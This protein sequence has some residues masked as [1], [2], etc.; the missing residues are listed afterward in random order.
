MAFNTECLQ[1]DEFINFYWKEK[2]T[3]H[4]GITNISTKPLINEREK[5]K[6]KLKEELIFPEIQPL[7]QN[8]EKAFN[9]ECLAE[10]RNFY[11]PENTNKFTKIQMKRMNVLLFA[12]MRKILEDFND[13]STIDCISKYFDSIKG[14]KDKIN[15]DSLGI[16]LF[17]KLVSDISKGNVQIKEKNLD[18]ML[19]NNK[20]IRPLSFYGETKEYF[21]LDKALDKIIDFLKEIISDEK[22]KDINK[23]KA[24]KIIFN[25]ALAKGSLKNLLDVISLLDKLPKKNIDLNYELNLI[26]N[27]FRKFGLG[28]PK[29]N[30]KSMESQVWNYSSKPDEGEKNISNNN[31]DKEK[32]DYYSITND[33]TY[34][35]YFSSKGV[36]LKIGTGFNNTMLGKVYNKKENY[37]HGEKGTIAYVEGILYYR[38]SNLDPEP[39]ISI[40]PETLEEIPNK[41]SVDYSEINHIFVEEKRIEFEFPHT[42]YKDMNE[43]IE[44]KK[45]AGLED[46]ANLLPSNPSPMISDGRFIYIISKWFDEE[47]ESDKK[48]EE[49]DVEVVENNENKDNKEKNVYGV[50]IY[51]PL[52]NMCHVRCLQLIP[53]LTEKEEE[54]VIEIKEKNKPKR[55]LNRRVPGARRERGFVW[56]GFLGQNERRDEEDINYDNPNGELNSGKDNK[57][58][59][60]DSSQITLPKDFLQGQNKLYTNGAILYINQYKFSLATGQLIGYCDLNSNKTNSFCYDFNNNLIWCIY[61]DPYLEDKI[62][63]N[64]FYN[65]SAKLNYEYPKDHPKYSPGNIEKIIEFCEKNIKMINLKEE[66]TN[67]KYKHQETLDL[68]GLADDESKKYKEV[69]IIND[70]IENNF[71]QYKLNLQ[72]FILNII[73]KVS[74]FYGQVPDLKIASNDIERGKILSQAMRRPY[75]VKLDPNTFKELIGLMI[76]YSQNFIKGNYSD[77]EAF[78]LLATVKIISTNLKCFLFK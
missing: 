51:D 53:I 63:I 25:L 50:N 35:Y 4:L 5:E 13:N 73:A 67:K 66:V 11:I 39:I 68:L 77:I 46:K 42:S 8:P 21:I 31:K 27:E 64:S 19:E 74:E 52:N 49:D 61:R 76:Q 10:Y 16:N 69:K 12:Y 18:F 26:K 6:F 22:E 37:R 55:D 58:E 65:E 48:D 41:F 2:S 47:N 7:N 71:E 70:S 56:G 60:I 59:G 45:N 17:I 32:I 20:F 72:C 44:R 54:N 24:L 33:G 3:E 38:S 36:L 34:L 23:M 28:E 78:C 29:S 9:I 75:C 15:Y 30:N 43:I 14:N 1:L 57:K 40:D 62:T